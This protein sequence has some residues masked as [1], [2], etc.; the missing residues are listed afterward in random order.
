MKVL[1]FSFFGGLMLPI[2]LFAQDEGL[3][4][5]LQNPGYIEEPEWFK[6][7]F[8]DIREDIQD[9]TAQN[10]RVLLYF[11]QDGC[12]YCEK[13]IKDNFGQ[14]ETTELTQS[15]FDTISINLWGDREVVGF[16]GEEL[17][18]KEFS[19]S[20]RVQFT[21]TLLMLDEKGE[22]AL[23]VNGYYPPGKFQMA[24]HYAGGKLAK[25]VSFRDYLASTP[26]RNASGKLHVNPTYLKA[27]LK[28]RDTLKDS[29]KPLLVMFEQKQCLACD[30]L[31]TDILQRE[32][33]LKLLKGFD[34]ALVDMW[35]ATEIQTPGGQVKKIRQWAADLGVAYTPTMAFFNANG[36]LVFRTDGYLRAF[37]TNASMAYVLEEAYLTEPEFQRFVEHRADTMRA[38]GLEVDL[39]K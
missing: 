21:P 12:P 16:K 26:I 22:I 34:V 14:R 15:L 4:A 24:L 2:C 19:K 3:D 29:T 33:S 17:T 5:N 7:S 1:L 23:R 20:L 8:L 13:L 9:A 36:E 18:E 39:M 32:E 35:S 37:H 25:P 30:E 28:L 31:H 38:A 11:H 10:K 6:E 27:P